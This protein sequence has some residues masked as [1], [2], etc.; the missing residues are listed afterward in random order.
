MVEKYL[1]T[2]GEVPSGGTKRQRELLTELMA[3]RE[4][5]LGVRTVYVKGGISYKEASEHIGKEQK[6]N[7][8]L[9]KG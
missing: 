1:P 2:S 3:H 5:P 7:G 4:E 9:S 6:G 8:R